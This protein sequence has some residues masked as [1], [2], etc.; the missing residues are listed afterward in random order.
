MTR[1]RRHSIDLGQLQ[2][3][4]RQRPTGGIAGLGERLKVINPY[5]G[6]NPDGNCFNCA[7]EVAEVL[8][9]GRTPQAHPVNEDVSNDGPPAP[10]RFDSG[11]T[12]GQD[13][14]DWLRNTAA[15]GGVYAVDGD[16]HAYN[17]VKDYNSRV[18][19]MDSNQHLFREV[20]RLQD[21]AAT[22]YN[23]DIYDSVQSN[24]ADP[25]DVHQ[26]TVYYW[27]TLH[28]TWRDIL[29]S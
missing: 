6:V 27:G 4:G 29:Q 7:R 2:G 19:I 1:L 13:V 18:Y 26:I 5:C 15:S 22:N 16:D 24:Y 9:T 23:E 21:F 14:W 25:P 8:T 10:K 20:K 3:V 28:P 17:F 12:R 11:P